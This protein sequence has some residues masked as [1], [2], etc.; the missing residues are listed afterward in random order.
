[1][2]TLY[3]NQ[4]LGYLENIEV[5]SKNIFLNKNVLNKCNDYFFHLSWIFLWLV[6]PNAAISLAECSWWAG[7]DM[8][9]TYQRISWWLFFSLLYPLCKYRIR[10]FI[11]L[12]SPITTKLNVI[13]KLYLH[14]TQDLSTSIWILH[15]KICP[16]LA[17]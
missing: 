11:L 6:I 9:I 17:K 4:C 2:A 16:Y 13:S 1:M 15:V 8:C 10:W 7:R 5:Y 14:Q 3:I 12:Q